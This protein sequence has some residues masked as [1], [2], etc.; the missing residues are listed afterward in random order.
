M[1]GDPQGLRG[2]WW[3]YTDTRWSAGDDPTGTGG[4]PKGAMTKLFFGLVFIA[5]LIKRGVADADC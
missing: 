5:F 4:E 2:A 3:P 1:D